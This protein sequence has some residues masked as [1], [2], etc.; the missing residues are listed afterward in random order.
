VW[1]VPLAA[2]LD[3]AAVLPAAARVFG[4]GAP[5]AE[6]IGD[7]RLLLLLDNFEHVIEAAS[8]LPAL[9]GACPRLDVLVTSRERLRVQGEHVYAVPVLERSEARRLFVTRAREVDP[10]F[11]HDDQVDEIC[12]R[13]DDL[14]LALELA[15][16]RTSLLTTTQLLERFG[17]R[18]DLLRGGRDTELRQRTLRATIE[19]SSSL[20]ASTRRAACSGPNSSCR[21]GRASTWHSRGRSRRARSHSGSAWSG[22][23]S[24]T[25]PPA[26]LW[27]RGSGSTRFSH[28]RAGR[29]K[30][31]SAPVHCEFAARPST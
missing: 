21:S 25:S 17:S 31:A 24:F 19:W 8:E 1:W 11:Q 22:C 18:L 5:V 30:P 23:S 3:A 15:A 16:A 7:R 9:L 13:L 27:R 20:Q 4:A 14:P 10:A 28:A 12:S 2:L 29:S 6:T 26:T